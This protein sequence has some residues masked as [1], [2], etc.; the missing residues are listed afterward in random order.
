MISSFCFITFTK[1]CLNY[2]LNYLHVRNTSVC[3]E[4]LIRQRYDEITQR[5]DRR[6]L[7][8]YSDGKPTWM[9]GVQTDHDAR[10]VESIHFNHLL[11]FFFFFKCCFQ[12]WRFALE[13][14]VFFREQVAIMAMACLS[15]LSGHEFPPRKI[16]QLSSR[17]KRKPNR[18][19]TSDIDYTSVFPPPGFNQKKVLFL[20]EEW[21]KKA[22]NKG[23]T[24]FNLEKEKKNEISN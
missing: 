6:K 24:F 19:L 17:A 21:K 23:I 14:D 3:M 10:G 20:V 2:C 8:S 11:F 1:S 15:N 4:P 22:R 7:I 16:T 18:S 5:R 13:E 9:F 12:T